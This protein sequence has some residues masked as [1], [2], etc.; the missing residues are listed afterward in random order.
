MTYLLEIEQL[1]KEMKEIE[2]EIVAL[3]KLN[4]VSVDDLTRQD[5]EDRIISKEFQRTM[6]HHTICGI[7]SKHEKICFMCL[8]NGVVR[9]A[10][11]ATDGLGFP[12]CLSHK[13]AE[14]KR[15][16]KKEGEGM[17]ICPTCN[18]RFPIVKG[19]IDHEPG[20]DCKKMDALSWIRK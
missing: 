12:C 2:E 5:T 13:K 14:E 4:E 11:T 3:R 8:F 19:K 10:Q 17:G 16:R 15:K 6:K 1:Q 20:V 7:R 9:G 18:R